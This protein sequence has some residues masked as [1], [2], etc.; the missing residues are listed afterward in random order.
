MYPK[1]LVYIKGKNKIKLNSNEKGKES[2]EVDEMFA[3]YV[4]AGISVAAITV[5]THDNKYIQPNLGIKTLEKLEKYEVDILGNYHQ[6]K[7]PEKRLPFNIN[8]K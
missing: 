6:V 3:Y 1:D 2:I 5:Q 8:K 7:L 4:K